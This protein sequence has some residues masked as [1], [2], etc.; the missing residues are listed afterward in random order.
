MA[1]FGC[2]LAARFEIFDKRNIGRCAADIQ[3]QDIFEP[4][5]LRN[6]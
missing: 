3:G 1:D 6:P 4:G 2:A 5:I